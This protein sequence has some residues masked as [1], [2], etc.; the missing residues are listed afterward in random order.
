MVFAVNTESAFSLIN[1]E[2]FIGTSGMKFKSTF[3]AKEVEMS[4]TIMTISGLIDP[5]PLVP[6]AFGLGMNI[7]TVSGK[8]GTNEYELK[9]ASLT[10][11]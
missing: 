2:G 7:P 8:E 10:F 1:G 11:L 6:V 5:I 9:G 3:D 4:G